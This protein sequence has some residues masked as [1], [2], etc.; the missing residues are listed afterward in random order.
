LVT[1]SPPGFD[2]VVSLSAARPAVPVPSLAYSATNR[3][4]LPLLAACQK[5]PSSLARPP[6]ATPD[7]ASVSFHPPREKLLEGGDPPEPCRRRSRRRS[8]SARRRR[9]STPRTQ[10]SRRRD[11]AR[12]PPP[13]ARS[14]SSL[15]APSFAS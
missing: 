13:H 14:G 5:Q 12:P 8:R 10:P 11:P 3:F 2:V 4:C 6:E 9:P 15:Y 1:P 7:F